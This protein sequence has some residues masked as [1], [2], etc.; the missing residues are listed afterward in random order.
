MYIKLK[1]ILISYY[2]LQLIIYETFFYSHIFIRLQFI[3]I[4]YGL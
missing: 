2:N 4:D 3:T 1:V